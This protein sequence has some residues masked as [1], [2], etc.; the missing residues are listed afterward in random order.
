MKDVPRTFSD[1]FYVFEK[2]V[3]ESSLENE[4]FEKFGNFININLHF[5]RRTIYWRTSN[6]MIAN[7][8]WKISKN[9]YKL[10]DQ[11]FERVHVLKYTV[12]L[13]TLKPF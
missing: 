11:I 13:L 4:F 3:L 10:Q 12:V 8:A 5:E 1:V 2:N 7:H 9:L 6:K